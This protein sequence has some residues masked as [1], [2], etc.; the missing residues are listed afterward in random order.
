MGRWDPESD[1][2]SLVYLCMHLLTGGDLPWFSE[3]TVNDVLDQQLTCN[4]DLLQVK[5]K[6]MVYFER[7]MKDNNLSGEKRQFAL[8]LAKIA[9]ATEKLAEWRK[10]I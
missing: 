4:E 7:W 3:Q 9:T 2:E 10:H 1:L 5:L 6:M 8:K